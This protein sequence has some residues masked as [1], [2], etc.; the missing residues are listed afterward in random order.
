MNREN[1]EPQDEMKEVLNEQEVNQ[2]EGSVQSAEP[3]GE[4]EGLGQS[5]PSQEESHQEGVQEQE[6][7]RNNPDFKAGQ[8]AMKKA[9]Q[10][11]FDRRINK[12]YSKFKSRED[13]ISLKFEQK[14]QELERKM[15]PLQEPK[16]ESF[17]NPNDFVKASIEYHKEK[18]NI[19]PGT[20]SPSNETYQ[21]SE[22]EINFAR[23]AEEYSKNHPDY[24][25]K[26]RQ[27]LPF[28]NQNPAFYEAIA[29]AGP[30]VAEYLADN[31]HIADDLAYQS[32]LQLGREISKIEN[33]IKMSKPLPK[34][35]VQ[36]SKPTTK[37]RGAGTKVT[38]LDQ[39][40]SQEEY[41]QIM[42]SL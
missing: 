23:K 33:E 9:Q 4:E 16:A 13:E 32:P 11:A 42:N 34:K 30:E 5:E 38:S 25:V 18:G 19:K 15:N 12:M 3:V 29:L 10:E 1:L 39:A 7:D 37:I 14:L 17:E 8:E 28:T 26:A 6:V 41:D 21:P 36:K 24:F 22:L 27:L 20:P 35:A 2:E 31:L 40:T